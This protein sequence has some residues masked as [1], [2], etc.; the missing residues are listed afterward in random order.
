MSTIFAEFQKGDKKTSR[1]LNSFSRKAK[2][3]SFWGALFISPWF[4]GFL[5]WTLIPMVASL[6]FSF[7]DFNLLKP[8]EIH[9]IGLQNYKKFFNDPLMMD[10][11]RVSLIFAAISFPIGIIQPILMAVMLNAKNLKG[12]RFFTT[13]FY[14]PYIIPMVSGVYIWRGMLNQKTGWYNLILQKFGSQGPDWLNDPNWIYPAL[15]LIGF[16]GVGN[17]LLFHLAA[18]QG[19]P[20]ELYEAAEIDGAGNIGKFWH[21]TLPMITPMIFYNMVLSAIGIVQYFLVPFVLN[22]GN[23]E[24]GNKTLFYALQLYKEAFAYSNMGYGS[25]LAWILFLFVL[26]ITIILFGTAKHW[27]YYTAAGKD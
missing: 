16:W 1:S 2:R 19:I 18:I 4:I 26:V 17:M 5:F 22:G 14:M 3:E 27:V 13:L 15:V 10:A 12:K 20:T 8:D 6:V 21:I 7:T 23:G 9:F 11:T 24:P 25:A